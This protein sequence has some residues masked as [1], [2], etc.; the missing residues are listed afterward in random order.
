MDGGTMNR[1]HYKD[2]TAEIAIARSMK[3]QR[4][5]DKRKKDRHGEAKTPGQRRNTPRT[6]RE[7]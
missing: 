4:Q 5:Q 1:E 3:H 7:E 6:V 2:P